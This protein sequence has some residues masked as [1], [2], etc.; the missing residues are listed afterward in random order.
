[1]RKRVPRRWLAAV[2]ACLLA[3][4]VATWAASGLASGSSSG[5]SGKTFKVALLLPGS[6]TDH[7]YNADG[8]RTADAIKKQLK[9]QVTY[10]QGV[11]IPNQADVYRRYASRGYDLVIGWGGQF[12]DGAVQVAREFPKVKFLIVNSNATNG[13]NLAAYDQEPTPYEFLGG[14]ILAKMSKTHV[15]GYIGAQCFPGTAKTFHGFEQGVKYGDPKAKLLKTFTQ[16]FEDPTKAQQATQALIDAK[17]D[18]LSGNLNNAWFGVFKAANDARPRARVVT[19]WSDNHTLAPKVIVSSVLKSQTRFV[20]QVARTALNGKWKGKFYLFGLPKN[21][22]PA[23]SKT[24]LLPAALYK[25]ALKVQQKLSAK[26]IKY[27]VD[28]SCP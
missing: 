16:D 21:Y 24:S 8:K 11:S 27:K 18:G 23:I 1:M 14:Y 17:A 7:G 22:G 4:A 2:L 6:I 12:T 3:A 19:E 26:K 25:Q 10:T 9:A 15:I 13:K 5:A 20:V 28:T